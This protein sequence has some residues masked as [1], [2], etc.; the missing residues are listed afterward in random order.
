MKK[1]FLIILVLI[2]GISINTKAQEMKKGT[3]FLSLGVGPSLNYYHF[4]AVGTFGGTP[5]VRV[6]FDHGFKKVG[7]GTISLGGLVGSFAK[8]YKGIYTDGIWPAVNTYN[9]TQHY[10]YLIVA[11]RAAYYYN[12]GKLIN[13]PE[14]NAYAGFATGVRQRFYSYSGPATYRPTYQG[15]ADFH[16]AAFAGANY[17]VT[18][19]IAFFTE[20]G[21]DISYFTAGVTFHL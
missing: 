12:F 1:T 16:T 14:L 13:T 3:N 9:Y 2:S 18:K 10:V 21:Y 8:T 6:S 20:F 5:A 15:G 11:F 17:F 4:S 19:K 7:P